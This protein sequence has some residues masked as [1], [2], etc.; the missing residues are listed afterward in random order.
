MATET[1]DINKIKG[2]L[3]S[4]LVLFGKV[5]MPNM[6]SSASPEFHYKIAKRL[7][8]E[9]IKQINIVAPRGHAK[10]SIVGGIF[11]LYHLMFHEGQK[12]IVLVSRTQDHAIKLLGTI[13]DCLDFSA[14]FRGLFGYWGQHSARQWSKSEIELKVIILFGLVMVVKEIIKGEQTTI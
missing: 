9:E 7:M 6:F 4:N 2:K 10:S 5:C 1:K 14:N 8:N 11:P 12:L 3:V 13:K